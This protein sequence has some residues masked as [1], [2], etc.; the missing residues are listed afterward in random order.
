MTDPMKRDDGK[1]RER[2]K[3]DGDDLSARLKSLDAKL[4][5]A[6]KRDLKG[7]M[8]LGG[9]SRLDSTAFG[10]AMRLPAEFASGV[11]AGG[12]LGWLIDWLFGSSPWGLIVCIALGFCAGILN[13]LRATGKVKP[14]QFDDDQK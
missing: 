12:S 4:G 14:S 5:H 13:L 7:K 8:L 3:P 2:E 10:K 6:A 1:D 9:M 11:I